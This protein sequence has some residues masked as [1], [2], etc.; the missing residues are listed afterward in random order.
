[1]SDE[2]TAPTEGVPAFDVSL[3]DPAECGGVTPGELG[4]FGDFGDLASLPNSIAE[5][6]RLC[7][8]PSWPRRLCGL[9]LLAGMLVK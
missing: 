7:R 3:D 5:V 2:D 8:D 1:M 4:D 6:L 9:L